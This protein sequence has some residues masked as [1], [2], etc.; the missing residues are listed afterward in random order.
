MAEKS[1]I[2]PGSGKDVEKERAEK[3]E[4]IMGKIN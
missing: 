4:E 3:I 1:K 2:F